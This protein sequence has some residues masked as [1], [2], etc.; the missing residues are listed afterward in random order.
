MSTIFI[1]HSSKDLA[2]AQTICA[3][4]EGRGLKCWIASRDVGA[5]D[6]FQEAIVAAIR[7]AKV[8]VLVFSDNAN[9]STEIKKELALASQ[10]KV[11]VIPA[12]V[13]DVV[14]AAALAYELATRQWI[15]LFNDWESEIETLCDRIKQIVPPVASASRPSQPAAQLSTPPAVGSILPPAAA[16]AVTT[17]VAPG[18]P[19]A[20][21]I[22]PLWLAATL[23]I[24][25]LAR[26]GLSST[27]I[28]FVTRNRDEWRL[29]DYLM[30]ADALTAG[31][32]IVLAGVLVM[33]TARWATATATAVC[34]VAL[35]HDAVWL[36]LWYF[37][38]ANAGA[39]AIVFHFGP[40]VVSAVACA[41]VLGI[42]IR[43]R[44]AGLCASFAPRRPLAACSQ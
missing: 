41:S 19:E 38:H 20:A 8:M 32:M 7:T 5:G 1:S 16:A 39:E 11:A 28:A 37:V 6:N 22:A 18:E 26:L 17:P 4:L 14:P 15:N 36:G 24:L 25:G 13:E 9:N 43:R 44:T 34:I 33:V 27:F 10:N 2:V 12:R 35:L 23:V 40:M 21:R 3:A 42:Q 30:T 29:T 31:V